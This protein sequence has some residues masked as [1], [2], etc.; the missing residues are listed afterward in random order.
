MQRVYYL[1]PGDW[2]GIIDGMLVI[3]GKTQNGFAV[4]EYRD[5]FDADGNLIGQ[6]TIKRSYSITRHDLQYEVYRYTGHIYGFC[7]YTEDP[8]Y[9]EEEEEGVPF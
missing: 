8:D 2:I 3:E 9:H 6:K 5:E 1:K 7:W 4:T